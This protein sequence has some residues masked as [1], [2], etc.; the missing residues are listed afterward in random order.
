MTVMR[1]RKK[2]DSVFQIRLPSEMHQ[3]LKDYAGRSNTSM[4]EVVKDALETVWK[5]DVIQQGK[6]EEVMTP[7]MLEVAKRYFEEQLKREES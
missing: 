4:S 6:M 5:K 1:M 3:W 7:E 2:S